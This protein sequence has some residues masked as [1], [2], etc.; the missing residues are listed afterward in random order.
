MTDYVQ[1][2]RIKDKAIEYLV[3]D[4]DHTVVCFHMHNVLT[5]YE[6][7][8]HNMARLL[9]AKVD[10]V[11]L[12]EAAQIA[13][14]VL[15]A[16]F[17][18]G[19]Q[20]EN[21]GLQV[22]PFE[23]FKAL[24]EENKKHWRK[25]GPRWQGENPKDHKSLEF[26]LSRIFGA[27]PSAHFMRRE[28][29]IEVI[30]AAQ[31]RGKQVIVASYSSYPAAVRWF[32]GKLKSPNERKE[33]IAG[34]AE[35]IIIQC[36]FPQVNQGSYSI[37]VSAEKLDRRIWKSHPQFGK[38]MHMIAALLRL[39][40]RDKTLNQSARDFCAVD[41][42]KLAVH[43]AR[44]SVTNEGGIENFFTESAQRT[45]DEWAKLSFVFGSKKGKDLV[46]MRFSAAEIQYILYGVEVVHAGED[47]AQGLAESLNFAALQTCARQFVLLDDNERN[48]EIATLHGMHAVLVEPETP[49]ELAQSEAGYDSNHYLGLG[50][51]ADRRRFLAA[52]QE[53]PGEDSASS[54]RQQS[55]SS[56]SSSSSRL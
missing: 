25:S 35:K 26:L 51:A 53:G 16:K 9:R 42:R 44:T 18:T 43:M 46:E 5:A 38:T 48:I 30:H 17:T 23:V 15:K 37:T 39:A 14:K 13:H 41:A 24:F 3:V 54:S 4:F 33:R 49:E 21:S 7:A 22:I 2:S 50:T 12:D 20:F 29:L 1:D 19:G 31:D 55:S 10:P 32:V 45:P 34:R 27:D 28:Q 8:Y 52:A 47:S 40:K 56:S 6:E 36:G 11:G